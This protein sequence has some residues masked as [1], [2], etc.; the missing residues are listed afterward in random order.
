MLASASV[1]LLSDFRDYWCV[2]VPP[3]IRCFFSLRRWYFWWFLELFAI[4]LCWLLLMKTFSADY[5]F[6]WWHFRH[7]L[8]IIIFFIFEISTFISPYGFQHWW[9]RVIS[10]DLFHFAKHFLCRNYFDV[11]RQLAE[12]TSSR[13][14]FITWLL[15]I[16]WCRLFISRDDIDADISFHYYFELMKD[17]SLMRWC[18]PAFILMFHFSIIFFVNIII[19][20][21]FAWCWLLR[22]LFRLFHFLDDYFDIDYFAGFLLIS[23]FLWLF[24]LHFFLL[25]RLIF[26]FFFF[27]ISLR[28]IAFSFSM[29]IFSRV[30]IISTL[31]IFFF[32]YTPFSLLHYR[33]GVCSFAGSRCKLFLRF[34]LHYW[35]FDVIFRWWCLFH[36]EL[37]TLSSFSIIFFSWGFDCCLLLRFRLISIFVS[38]FF[39]RFLR[40]LSCSRLISFFIS[41]CFFDAFLDFSFLRYFCQDWLIDFRFLLF[42]IFIFRG[43]RWHFDYFISSLHASFSLSTFSFLSLMKCFFAFFMGNIFSHFSAGKISL[44]FKVSADYW[45]NIFISLFSFISMCGG[46]ISFRFSA[47]CRL[48]SFLFSSR[49]YFFVDSCKADVHWL[50]L[51]RFRLIISLFFFISSFILLPLMYYFSSFF[52][53]VLSLSIV[54]F[55]EMIFF[56]LPCFFHFSHFSPLFS[57]DDFLFGE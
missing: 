14:S 11:P 19:A 9:V 43:F 28:G 37:S 12:Y 44:M 18:V 35:Y 21:F 29:L 23:F 53:D 38:I 33:D 2:G 31:I 6:R 10:S 26:F 20:L 25:Q 30:F 24:L 16:D 17:M 55:L 51:I 49:A 1:S 7:Y 41:R 39:F 46:K 34:S 56:H 57:P 8:K 50:M 15:I 42:F 54:H 13:C 22:F 4:F 5:H 40:L 3:L 45:W 52:A 32:D 47:M 48:F 27:D 36:C